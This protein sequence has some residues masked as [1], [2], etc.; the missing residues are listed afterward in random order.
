MA[1]LSESSAPFRGKDDFVVRVLPPLVIS[2]KAEKYERPGVWE[3]GPVHASAFPR[4][5]LSIA[6]SDSVLNHP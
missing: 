6:N 1:C 5:R 4:W 3:R 2:S